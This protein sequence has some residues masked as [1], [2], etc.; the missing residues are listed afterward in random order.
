MW[1]ACK[2]G[3][4]KPMITIIFI[5]LVRKKK[6]LFSFLFVHVSI[7]IFHFTT[8]IQYNYT[9]TN[10]SSDG[11]KLYWL[12]EPYEHNL[13]FSCMGNKVMIHFSAVSY[14]WG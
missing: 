3:S 10:L 1:I 14:Y 11:Y 4:A 13:S 9:S 8:A 5:M 12:I 7:S 6:L 2:M